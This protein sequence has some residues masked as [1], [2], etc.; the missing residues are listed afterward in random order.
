MND[1]SRN[2]SNR[3]F[4]QEI[5]SK[6]GI[7][8]AKEIREVTA[9]NP[10]VARELRRI[11][12]SGQQ[13]ASSPGSMADGAVQTSTAEQAE[14]AFPA[15]A[16]ADGKP[17][18]GQKKSV[19]RRART[20]T[21]LQNHQARC[22]ICN[23][24]AREE[25]DE[26]FV[27]WDNVRQLAYDYKVDRRALY[28]HAH[29]TGLYEQRDRNIRRALGRIIQEADAVAPSADAIIRAIKILTHINSRGEW[30]NPAT[31]VVFSTEPR[32]GAARNSSREVTHH[33][34]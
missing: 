23:S 1:E 10:R 19:A 16:A 13:P 24:D 33:A 20:T 30:V 34:K 18:T 5:K 9:I 8:I 14:A 7:D 6:H 15:N 3:R 17:L 27:S 21:R 26:A 31:R 12:D 2:A 32:A 11:L 4:E 28:R 22:R 25:I 29:A